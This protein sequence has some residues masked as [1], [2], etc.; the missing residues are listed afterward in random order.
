MIIHVI[1]VG[2]DGKFIDYSDEPLSNHLQWLRE[3]WMDD[4]LPQTFACVDENGVVEAV[5]MRDKF[6][7]E[8]AHT[9]YRDGTTARHRCQYQYDANGNYDFTLVTDISGYCWLKL[10]DINQ[11]CRTLPS[12]N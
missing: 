3:M 7:P 4:S 6:D 12:Q 5:I 10:R 1:L 9:L 11:D 8:I 2:L